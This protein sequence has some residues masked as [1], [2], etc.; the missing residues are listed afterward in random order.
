VPANCTAVQPA[1]DTAQFTA[2]CTTEQRSHDP[3]FVSAL[4][5]ALF[6]AFRTA[7]QCAV[8]AADGDT[9]LPTVESA[10]C[11][12]VDA[13]KHTTVVS[14]FAAAVEPTL[15]YALC[16]AF[17]GTFQAAK[18][19]AVVDAIDAAY[20]YPECAALYAA[21]V[22]AVDAAEYAAYRATLSATVCL[23]L[24]AALD[25]THCVSLDA[26]QCG[27][28][29]TT[30]ECPVSSTELSAYRAAF[31]P[32]DVRAHSVTLVSAFGSTQ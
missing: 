8:C 2:V 32:A 26:A 16:A 1:L 14:T 7:F 20:C 23:A 25:S 9:E 21:L 19:A 12:S 11:E 5:A 28:K 29:R 18:C 30:F 24:D 10:F 22:D 17:V 13:A 6:G 31:L 15:W 27:A 4:G 3:A